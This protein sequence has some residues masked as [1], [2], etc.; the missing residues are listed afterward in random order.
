MT[1]PFN[2]LT[3]RIILCDFAQASPDGKLTLVGAGWS[4][5]NPGPA[6]F[7][8][9]IMVEFDPSVVTT[10]HRFEL[11]VRDADGHPVSDPAGHPVR[12]NGLIPPQAAPVG[13]PAGMAVKAAFAF[14]FAGLPLSADGRFQIVLTVDDSI[15]VV[16]DF[17]TRPAQ[18]QLK[19][20]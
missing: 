18:P 15:I 17:G 13:H 9:G 1:T 10:P 5:I 7:G 12:M 16:E 14:N 6:M 2:G 3:A 19:A 11:T 4:F 20:S 8:V